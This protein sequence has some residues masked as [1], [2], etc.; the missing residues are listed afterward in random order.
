M[1]RKSG[2]LDEFIS[3]KMEEGEEEWKR[4]REIGRIM[5]KKWEKKRNSERKRDYR[6]NIKRSGRGIVRERENY[7]NQTK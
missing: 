6:E 4:E 2:R 1:E 5:K 3:Y 7:T